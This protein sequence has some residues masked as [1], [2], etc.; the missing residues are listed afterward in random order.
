MSKELSNKKIQDSVTVRVRPEK[1]KVFKIMA[2]EQQISI[3]NLIESTIPLLEEMKL[4][5]KSIDG[6]VL[7]GLENYF[8]KKDK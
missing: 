5:P 6:E 2:A 8:K 4:K 1:H 7:E 3:G